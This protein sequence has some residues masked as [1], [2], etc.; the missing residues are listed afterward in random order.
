M[1]GLPDT[2]VLYCILYILYFIYIV[3]YIYCILYNVFFKCK[4]GNTY[5]FDIVNGLGQI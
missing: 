3:F 4:L 5:L 1:K 2:P